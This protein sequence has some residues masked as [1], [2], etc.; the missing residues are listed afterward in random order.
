MNRDY[1]ITLIR[2]GITAGNDRKEYIGC[3]SDMLLSDKGIS[4]VQ[5]MAGNIRDIVGDMPTIISSPM[6][7]CIETAGYIWPDIKPEQVDDLKEMDFGDFEGKNY[8]DLN[9]NPEYQ[10]WIDSGGRAAFPNG[11]G[12]E[13]FS[14]RVMNALRSVLDNY[15]SG[16]GS[17]INE[18]T[19]V[20]HGGTI[21]AVMSSIFGEDYYDHIVGNLCGYTLELSY[22]GKNIFGKSYCSFTPGLCS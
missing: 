10:R 12:L 15:S 8:Q 18:V 22:D 2:H 11:E 17:R 19:I 4:Q 7:R 16:D 1:K 6:R 3:R 5:S 20:C 21:M 9:G 14:N 13:E